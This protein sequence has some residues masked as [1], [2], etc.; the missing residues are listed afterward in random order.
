ML[1]M[2]YF[3]VVKTKLGISEQGLSFFSKL[4]FQQA[5]FFQNL[6][7]VYITP[8]IVKT[9]FF[10][11]FL[12]LD[13]F[14][15]FEQIQI[16]QG[17]WQ[18]LS[19]N[20]TLSIWRKKVCPHNEN[21][22]FNKEIIS[23]RK[24]PKCAYSRTYSVCLSSPL[25]SMRENEKHYSNEKSLWKTENLHSMVRW[26]SLRPLSDHLW[27]SKQCGHCKKTPKG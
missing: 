7:R 5:F 6:Y 25:L 11:F 14:L 19:E 15:L 20:Y 18:P 21:A 12:N 3:F 24:F 4:V 27:R 8:C 1:D 17:K 16:I 26:E 2:F 9:D 23:T 13:L 10:F 22:I